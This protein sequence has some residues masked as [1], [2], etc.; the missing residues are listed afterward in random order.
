M[1]QR[2]IDLHVHTDNS[3]DGNHSAMFI[4]EKAEMGEL[5]AIAFCD[6]CEVDSFYEESYD[7][8]IRQAYF[9]MVKAQSAFRGKVVVL[10]GIELAQPHYLPELANDILSKYKYDQVIG[11]IHNLR[12]K[13]D[14]YF[15]ESFTKN[16]AELLFNEYLDEILN[17]LEWGDFDVLAHLTYPLRYF[18]AKSQISID[19]NDYKKKIDEILK[20]TA[21]KEKSLEINTAGLRQPIGKLSPEFETV[22]RF[23][24]LGGKFVSFG[25]DAHF[26]DDLA[27]G[28]DEAFDVM[29]A[30]GFTETTFFQQRTPL[31]M[32]IE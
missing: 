19:V 5:R 18:F 4:C 3:P 26:A 17:M 13:Q 16:E 20:L 15:I 2:K 28:I 30:A 10:R 22:K 21:E 11:S 8:R 7:K 14:F 1:Y 12:E 32:K 23:H 29:K 25:S 31:Q 27:K 6:H 9:E 24:E